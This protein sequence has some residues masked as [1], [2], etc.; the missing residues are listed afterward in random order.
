MVEKMGKG[1]HNGWRDE[2]RCPFEHIKL[3]KVP[4]LVRCFEV[5]VTLVS[6]HAS[7]LSKAFERRQRDELMCYH[8][9]GIGHSSASLQYQPHSI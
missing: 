6:I 1:N 2:K 5:A 9:L 4:I 3:C 8:S 7:T